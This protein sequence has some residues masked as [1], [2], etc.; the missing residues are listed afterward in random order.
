MMILK[1]LAAIPIVLAIWLACALFDVPHIG[2]WG[3]QYRYLPIIGVAA[4]VVLALCFL[5]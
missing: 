5:N 4:V 3:H 1:M 2:V